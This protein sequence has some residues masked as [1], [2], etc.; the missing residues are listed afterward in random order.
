[1]AWDGLRSVM[2]AFPGPTYSL[3][4]TEFANLNHKCL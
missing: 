2:E 4:F 3:L 1:M